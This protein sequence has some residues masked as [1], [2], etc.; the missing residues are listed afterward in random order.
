MSDTIR[1]GDVLTFRFDDERFLVGKI[2]RIEPLTLHDIVHIRLYDCLV[3][4]GPG[5]YDGAGVY[6]ERTHVVPD[7]SETS[8]VI[9]PLAVTSTGLADSDPFVIDHRE[10]TESELHGHAIWAHRRHESAVR[11][12]LIKYDDTEEEVDEE[13]DEELLE[14]EADDLGDSDNQPV[15]SALENATDDPDVEAAASVEVELMPWHDTVF[16]LPIARI[17]RDLAPTFERPSVSDSRLASAIGELRASILASVDDLISRLV[18]DGDYGAGQ[19]LLDVGE[20][21]VAPLAARLGTCSAEEAC[22]DIAQ[23]L[24]DLGIEPGY[25]ALGAELESRLPTLATDRAAQAVARSFLYAV[26]ITGGEPEPLR[27]RLDLIGKIDHPDLAG[28]VESATDAISDGSADIE[29]APTTRSADPF[30]F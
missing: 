7:L 4:A 13:F 8:V 17:L 28:D 2:V 26:M 6:R 22:G 21:V 1:A 27:K 14:D 25:D 19:E 23:I 16:D 29:E 18:D 11:R 15:D 12:G 9:D 24:A 30:G 5:G 3:E 20:S 10:V